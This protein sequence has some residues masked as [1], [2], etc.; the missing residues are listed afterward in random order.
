MNFFR[1]LDFIGT[2]FSVFFNYS[3][4]FFLKRIIDVIDTRNP[5]PDALARAYI[6]AF[7]MFAT[8]VLKAEADVQHLWYG[9][10]ASVRVRSSLMAAIYDKALKRKDFSGIGGRDNDKKDEKDADK[11]KGK[12]SK[13]GDDEPKAGADVGKVSSH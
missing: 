11:D 1:S 7:L 13:P 5:T 2:L 8:Q 4:P 9:R 3:G 10:R 12:K 6:Y